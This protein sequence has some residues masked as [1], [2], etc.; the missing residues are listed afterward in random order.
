MNKKLYL[1][2]KKKKSQ[3]QNKRGEFP[4]SGSMNADSQVGRDAEGSTDQ[5]GLGR[6]K[7]S[8]EPPF[9][10]TYPLGNTP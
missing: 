7:A 6:L 5:I 10:E 3:L 2:K 9:P 4:L 1:P 8:K